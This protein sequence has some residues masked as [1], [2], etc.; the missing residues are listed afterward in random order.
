MPGSVLELPVSHVE[1]GGG[2]SA[3]MELQVQQPFAGYL[4]YCGLV[5]LL[6]PLP[7]PG[8]LFFPEGEAQHTSISHPRALA[9]CF[10]LL[11]Q[12]LT[13]LSFSPG[14][15]PPL[16]LG[17]TSSLTSCPSWGDIPSGNTWDSPEAV[18]TSSWEGPIASH[19]YSSTLGAPLHSNNTWERLPCTWHCSR[20]QLRQG[21]LFCFVGNIFWFPDDLSVYVQ[22]LPSLLISVSLTPGTGDPQQIFVVQ[23]T[24]DVWERLARRTNV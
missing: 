24:E 13:W 16:G 8:S 19:G 9:L 17:S 12:L 10:H 6:F 20:G 14:S 2:A 18:F 7:L 5:A 15:R 4:G 23:V 22:V 21:L 3:H 1:P 11:G